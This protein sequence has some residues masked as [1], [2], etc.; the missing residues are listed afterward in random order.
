MT[1]RK[2]Q[3]SFHPLV[4]PPAE[5][6]C[7][8]KWHYTGVM[9]ELVGYLDKMADR[10]PTGERFVFTSVEYLL[11]NEKLK[12]F[13][14]AA[15]GERAIRYALAELR[16]RWI[17]SKPLHRERWMP[18]GQKGHLIL[19]RLKGSI[20]APHAS[21]AI[22]DGYTCRLGEPFTVPGTHW[23][24]ESSKLIYWVPAP[25]G[26]LHVPTR[27]LPQ[28]C[29]GNANALRASA[30]QSAAPSAGASAGQSAEC[31]AAPSAGASAEMISGQAI[32]PPSSSDQNRAPILCNRQQPVQPDE[33]TKPV[34]PDEPAPPKPAAQGENLSGVL[35]TGAAAPNPAN[36]TQ[37]IGQRF[38]GYDDEQILEEISDGEVDVYKLKI[39]GNPGRH[40][41]ETG[42]VETLAIYARKAIAEVADQTWEATHTA[43]ARLM[44]R[45]IR[46]MRAQNEEYPPGWLLVLKQLQRSTKTCSWKRTP[47]DDRRPIVVSDLAAARAQGKVD[48]PLTQK[49]A[50]NGQAMYLCSDAIYRLAGD[51]DHYGFTVQAADGVWDKP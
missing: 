24:Y 8:L 29:H 12:R 40:G 43:C 11:E 22:A 27:D 38:A 41:V 35:E 7:E 16:E 23:N 32:E 45:T 44:D 9:R 39:P 42:D 49:H 6:P 30:G 15:Y 18:S 26:G 28:Q 50:L 48:R 31:S 2:F 10:D 37:T 13:N 46:L 17:L 1:T 33:P 20:M 36:V 34:Y 47:S 3:T 21:L 4:K 25:V 14:G 5:E 51:R 19:R